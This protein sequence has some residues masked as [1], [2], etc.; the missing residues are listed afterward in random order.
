MTA[1]VHTGGSPAAAAYLFILALLENNLDHKEELGQMALKDALCK[2][3]TRDMLEHEIEGHMEHAKK[4]H[5]GGKHMTKEKLRAHTLA[6]MDHKHYSGPGGV[7]SEIPKVIRA[8]TKKKIEEIS[9]RQVVRM[10]QTDHAEAIISENEKHQVH[11][12]RSQ[13]LAKEIH[14]AAKVEDYIDAAHHEDLHCAV[15]FNW[16]ET[17]RD[18]TSRGK[19]GLVVIH[20]DT[21]FEVRSSATPWFKCEFD[22][23]EKRYRVHSFGNFPSKH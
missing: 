21:E 6:T 13:T 10:L 5:D 4:G 22:W 11:K 15:M 20:V 16:S 1:R 14:A 19:E 7:A 8:Q 9:L 23:E 17:R 2:K 18:L 3:C 12:R